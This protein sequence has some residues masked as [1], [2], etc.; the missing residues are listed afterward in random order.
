MNN[1]MV[2]PLKTDNLHV[3]ADIVDPK[4]GSELVSR[5]L[6][7]VANSKLCS[8]HLHTAEMMVTI[9][10]KGPVV[11]HPQ[12]VVV[13]QT[14]VTDMVLAN[15]NNPDKV[16]A[17]LG[18]AQGILSGDKGPNDAEVIPS[19]Q[20]FLRQASN[21]SSTVNKKRDQGRNHLS[22]PS[23]VAEGG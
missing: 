9:A 21:R 22:P 19:N 15:Q 1:G 4:C 10:P 2:V 17:L 5:C 8:K 7:C 12:E 3:L 18:H 6:N 16:S 23:A 14:D 13:I 20:P 11:E